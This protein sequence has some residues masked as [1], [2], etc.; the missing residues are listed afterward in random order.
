MLFRH[1]A[2][3]S[4]FFEKGLGRLHFLD[5]QA[6]VKEGS[7]LDEDRCRPPLERGLALSQEKIEFKGSSQVQSG[8]EKIHD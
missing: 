5:G 4:K 8:L 1:R 6:F 2:S 7:H 3:A